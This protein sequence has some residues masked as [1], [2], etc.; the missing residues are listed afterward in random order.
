MEKIDGKNFEEEVL[1]SKK[2][3][4]VDFYASWSPPSKTLEPVLMEVSQ[5]ITGVKFCKIDGELNYELSKKYNIE[6]TPTLIIFDHG[7]EIDRK[8]GMLSRMDLKEW[9]REN[10]IETS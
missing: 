4:V 1:K 2:P 9:I 10:F 3:V 7:R 5:E 8:I 6:R